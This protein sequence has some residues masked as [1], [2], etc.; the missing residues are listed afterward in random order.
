MTPSNPRTIRSTPPAGSSRSIG[1]SARKPRIGSRRWPR[2]DSPPILLAKRPGHLTKTFTEL[3]VSGC[4][5]TGVKLST[6]QNA[7][8]VRPDL[9]CATRPAQQ[10]ARVDTIRPQ[11]PACQYNGWEQLRVSTPARLR[12]R[13]CGPRA[14]P[15]MPHTRPCDSREMIPHLSHLWRSPGSSSK[16]SATRTRPLPAS[17]MM[18]W[19]TR[20]RPERGPPRSKISLDR[21]FS[22]W[23]PVRHRRRKTRVWPN[24]GFGNRS[25][26]ITSLSSAMSAPCDC[27]GGQGAQCALHSQRSRS[28]ERGC[29]R[30][31]AQREHRYGEQ[32]D[33]E[34]GCRAPVT[35]GSG[36]AAIH[37]PLQL[38]EA[39][40]QRSAPTGPVDAA[41]TPALDV[42]GQVGHPPQ[43]SRGGQ[44]D[45][46]RGQ[47]GYQGPSPPSPIT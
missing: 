27:A 13:L 10:T 35:R 11:T 45:K 8:I 21:P 36:A 2:S 39:P 38:S 16:I 47:L 5:A 9:R 19:R 32:G 1:A 15:P 40:D 46:G 43:Q 23:W 22:R 44:I 14:C 25:L 24:S 29:Q 7:H 37:T 20:T 18:C 42:P 33:G 4:A 31:Q 41:I 26:S 34:P 28:R 3:H 6:L 17:C 12:S 30:H